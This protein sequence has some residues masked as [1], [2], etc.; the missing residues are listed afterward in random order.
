[1]TMA[2]RFLR[3]FERIGEEQS[4][5]KDRIATLQR[6]LSEVTAERD[7]M[8]MALT[9]LVSYRDYMHPGDVKIAEEALG[10]E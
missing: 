4:Q 1:M 10:D 3:A 7:A 5:M 9:V 8:R 6:Q 2:G